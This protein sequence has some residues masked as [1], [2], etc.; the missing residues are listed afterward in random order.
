MVHT[1]NKKLFV[2]CLKFTFDWVF[3]IF[4]CYT[5][6][7]DPKVPAVVFSM[8]LRVTSLMLLVSI[9][10]NISVSNRLFL[11]LTFLTFTLQPGCLKKKKSAGNLI[12]LNIKVLNDS[13]LPKGFS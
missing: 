12:L 9:T 5:W 8:L 1:Y 4:I 10:S 11:S 7:L 6:Q 13:V 2:G 3:H